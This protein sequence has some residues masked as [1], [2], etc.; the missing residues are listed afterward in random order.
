M[1][2]PRAIID[3]GTNTFQ[4][5]IAEKKS[6]DGK[7]NVL[8]EDHRPVGLG[9]GAMDTGL[10]Q[11]D[12]MA[13]ALEALERF[14]W[15]AQDKG[16]VSIQGIGTSI[17]RNARNAGA[18][19]ELVETQLEIPIQVISGIQEADYIFQGI[20]HSLPDPWNE[21]SLVMDIGGGSVEFILFQNQTIL[22]KTSLELGGLKLQSLF[23]LEGEYHA[24][25][26]KNLD[27]YIQAGLTTLYAA[28][29]E[30][31]PVYLIGA[32]GAF[33]TLADIQLAQGYLTQ[34]DKA[35]PLNL[36]AFFDLMDQMAQ[37]TLTER[38][39]IPGM[40]AF[41]ASMLPYANHLIAQVLGKTSI[42][43]LW[44]SMYS[45]KEGFWYKSQ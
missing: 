29:E 11:L 8:Y 14:R 41:R 12:A 21:V 10:L 18:F 35:N 36:A 15:H 42:K 1:P 37:L 32:A 4:L 16:C 5:L 45:L 17:L 27:A 2:K 43:E 33:E 30:H 13:R 20:R 34:M 9:K 31:R 24:C 38:Q 39:A 7:M 22:F 25:V 40:K 28:C 3:L 26:S 6:S 23:N 19:I 44:M